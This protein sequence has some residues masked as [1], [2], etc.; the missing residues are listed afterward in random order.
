MITSSQSILIDP[1]SVKARRGSEGHLDANPTYHYNREHFNLLNLDDSTLLI[2]YGTNPDGKLIKKAEVYTA[3]DHRID[4]TLIDLDARRII[5]RLQREGFKAYIVGGAVRDLLTG[6]QPKDFDIATDA[7]PR[8][9]RKIF[10]NSRVIG[11]RFRLVHIYSEREGKGKIFEV[12][13]FR[14]SQ[15]S[16]HSRGTSIYGSV[17]EDVWRRDFTVN[18]LYYCPERGIIIDFVGGYRDIQEK[19][20]C[21]LIPADTSFREDPV[22]MIRGIKY[23]EMTGFP[24]G[25]ALTASIKRHRRRL[26]GCSAARLTEELYKIL[27]SGHSA[28]IFLQSYRLKLLEVFFPTLHDRWHS[29]GRRQLLENLR[30]NLDLLDRH[31]KKDTLSRG[32]MLGYL[33]RSFNKRWDP[34]T[35]VEQVMVWIQESCKPLIPSR[36]ECQRAATLLL[37]WTTA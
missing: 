21:P 32:S 37:R 35:D 2:R 1:D 7:L 23:A 33:M 16:E 10:P 11:R 34:S 9:L 3:E 24:L 15:R 8:R 22:R 12:S 17:E 26:S 25:P 13:T 27:S 28:A 31:V 29:L 5:R 30:A 36:K 20:I 4:P 14:A 6:L 19:K 18:A